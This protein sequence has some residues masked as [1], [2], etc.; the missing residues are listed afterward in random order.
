MKRTTLWPSTE[1]HTHQPEKWDPH[2][3]PMGS[4]LNRINAWCGFIA[5]N[6]F[7]A[8]TKIQAGWKNVL[9]CY[10]FGSKIKLIGKIKKKWINY[11]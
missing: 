1:T 4:I 8:K 2:L 5:E 11:L 6:K 10:G 9:M 3:F 7:D